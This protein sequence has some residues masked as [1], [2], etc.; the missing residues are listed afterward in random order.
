MI[1][2]RF[3]DNGAIRTAYYDIGRGGTPL[4]LVHGFT[5]GKLDFHD[6]IGWF[7]DTRR[8]LAPDQRGHGETT[9]AA[10]YALDQLVADLAGFL[11]RTDV[12]RCHLLGHSMGGMVAM[13]FALAHPE[14][15][16]SLVLMD[17]MAEPISV[18]PR[19]AREHMRRQLADAGMASLVPTFKAAPTTPS[20]QRGIDFLG[21]AE[22]WR[23]IE[24][25]LGQMD[26]HAFVDLGA[27]IGDQRPLLDALPGIRCP[28]TVL[29]GADDVPFVAPSQRM[30]AAIPG[31]RLV[32]I[33]DAAHC[34]QYE[35]ATAWRAAIEA[36]IVRALHA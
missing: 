4:V 14:R 8:V 18:M 25:K 7:A 6:Q 5:G 33:P 24:E 31:A 21:E 10:P 22:H 19:D 27:E 20:V 36:H 2:S 34:P 9:N 35:N 11:D 28:T 29:V 17:T 32:V 26:P 12:D 15:L 1:A 13:R 30:T 23:R 3:V 16:A